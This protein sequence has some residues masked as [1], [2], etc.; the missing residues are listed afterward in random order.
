MSSGV[1]SLTDLRAAAARFSSIYRTSPE[2]GSISS[3][4]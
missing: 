4:V 2:V 3:R 1:F